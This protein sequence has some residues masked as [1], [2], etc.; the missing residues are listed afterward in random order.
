MP[1]MRVEFWVNDDVRSIT[2]D[3]IKRDTNTLRVRQDGEV[4]GWFPYD[5]INHIVADDVE[6]DG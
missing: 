2:G 6:P 5:S 1:E 3:S 4:V